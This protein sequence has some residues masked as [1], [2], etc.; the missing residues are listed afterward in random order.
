MKHSNIRK[1]LKDSQ[2]TWIHTQAVFTDK[3]LLIKSYQVMQ[4]WEETY[5]K[6]LAAIATSNGGN[7]LEVGFGLGISA[8]YIQNYNNIKSHTV[9]EAHP[10]VIASAKEK[11]KAELASGR[12][13]LLESFWEDITPTLPEK[14][15]AGILFDTCPL[16]SGVEFF[17]FFPFFKEAYRLLEDN[18]VL[19]YFS[20][21]ATD[22][23]QQHREEL[24]NAGFTN[25]E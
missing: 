24:H 1:L 12:M 9:I 5:M 3:D 23:S 21:E 11:F 7:V 14:S 8:G 22:I 25:I 17:H 16:D 4:R 6:S 13:N 20:D 2:N 10:T 18:G 19:T 15:F